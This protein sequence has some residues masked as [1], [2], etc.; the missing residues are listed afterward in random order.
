MRG[1]N[2]SILRSMKIGARVCGNRAEGPIPGEGPILAAQVCCWT[3]E[4]ILEIPKGLINEKVWTPHGWFGCSQSTV[5]P[6]G[7]KTF[8][9]QVQV[10]PS[11]SR[12]AKK[13]AGQ[14]LGLAS[15]THPVKEERQVLGS[16]G[17]LERAQ[18][19][20]PGASAFSPEPQLLN[21]PLGDNRTLRCGERS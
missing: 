9:L 7:Q 12:C 16:C 17:A 2:P 1:N 14:V 3:V 11:I 18:N 8:H 10:F 5:R 21:L 4:E 19:Q 20:G 15:R 6:G 13:Q